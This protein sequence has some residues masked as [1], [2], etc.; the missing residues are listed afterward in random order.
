MDPKDF[1]VPAAGESQLLT[2]DRRTPV[3][4]PP[5]PAEPTLWQRF[6]LFVRNLLTWWVEAIDR[7]LGS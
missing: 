1:T 2:S 6:L 4:A 5:A 7:Q 3:A